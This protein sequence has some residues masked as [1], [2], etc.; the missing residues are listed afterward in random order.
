MQGNDS[1]LG[2]DGNDL[3]AANEGDDYLDG[4]P[5]NDTLQGG[6]GSDTY[7]FDRSSGSDLLQEL[8]QN[9]GDVDTVVFGDNIAR[10]DLV[11]KHS[12]TNDLLISVSGAS[13]ALTNNNW[14]RAD[15]PSHVERFVFRDG[16]VLSDSDIVAPLANADSTA[17][18]EDAASANLVP[19]LLA[20]DSGPD[21]R[22]AAV[23]T[24]G[25][26]GTVAF[27][28]TSQTLTY[29]ADA[30][31]QDAL[32]AGQ[33]AADTFSYTVNDPSGATSTATVT[34]IVTG[35]N[36]APVLATPLADQVAPENQLFSFQLPA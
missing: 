13:A 31:A 24:T 32:A 7:F 34:V 14:F 29:S 10:R 22:V 2:G 8:Q 20:N 12:G 15:I 17:V 5:G 21:A 4:G 28:A 35:V 16:T 19:L 6:T 3:L 23:D 33:T 26:V 27:D 25:T 9:P 1:L 11:V 30:A 36:D 18:A